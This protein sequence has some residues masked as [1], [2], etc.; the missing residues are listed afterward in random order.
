[1]LVQ[2]PTP[3]WYNQLLLF[4]Y[5]L[6]YEVSY[7]TYLYETMCNIVTISIAQNERVSAILR[8]SGMR[9]E[10]IDRSSQFAYF[11]APMVRPNNQKGTK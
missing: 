1:M 5:L 6:L 7:T 11:P 9:K 2:K 10:V 4:D 8:I 3:F